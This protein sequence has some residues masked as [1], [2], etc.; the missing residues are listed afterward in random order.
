MW[1]IDKSAG[2]GGDRLCLSLSWSCHR[3][4]GL[5]HPPRHV[6][7]GAQSDVLLLGHQTLTKPSTTVQLLS[8]I[9]IVGASPKAAHCEATSGQPTNQLPDQVEPETLPAAEEHHG[10]PNE[11]SR[12][13]DGTGIDATA[14]SGDVQR[15]AASQGSHRI[16]VLTPDGAGVDDRHEDEGKARLPDD[17]VQP[18]GVVQREA[19]RRRQVLVVAQ[20]YPRQQENL[21]QRADDAAQDLCRQV[22]PAHR[23]LG[24]AAEGLAIVRAGL[25]CPEEMGAA[26]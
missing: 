18:V 23:V 3:A 2:S 16:E 7:A 25:R 8:I 15:Q 1:P 24:V 5:K 4:S 12:V 11:T 17:S 26:M 9:A 14:L 13:Q 22:Q 6:V 10:W 20:M 19:P 21:Q